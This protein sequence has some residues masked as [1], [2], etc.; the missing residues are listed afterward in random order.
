MPV[1]GAQPIQADSGQRRNLLAFVD[2]E[3]ATAP[4]VYDLP[5]LFAEGSRHRGYAVIEVRQHLV[6]HVAHAV[7]VNDKDNNGQQPV[8][9]SGEDSPMDS[10]ARV[11]R[12]LKQRKQSMQWLAD[13]LGYSKQ[14]VA[15]WKARGAIPA[16]EHAAVAAAIGKSVDWVA[17]LTEADPPERDMSPMGRTIAREFDTIKDPERQ[18][19]CFAQIIAAIERAR[20]T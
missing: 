16:A 9:D 13:Q 3:A 2:G 12:L 1:L 4:V 11:Y 19:T 7:M 17:G 8:S 5:A 10:W 18:L 20:T 14:R 15:M 6:K